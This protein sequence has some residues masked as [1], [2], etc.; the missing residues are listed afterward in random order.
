MRPTLLLL[1]C[2]L[3]LAALGLAPA[4]TPSADQIKKLIEQLGDDSYAVRQK[5]SETLYKLGAPALDALQAATKH[6][7]A[8]VRRRASELYSRIEKVAETQQILTPTLVHLAFKNVPLNTAL[9]DFRK[10]SGFPIVLLDPDNKLASTKVT[11]DTGKVTFWS[12]LDKF[13][14]AAG[15]RESDNTTL[16]RT[17]GRPLP[18]GSAVLFP[19]GTATPG[20]VTRITL[21]AGKADKVAAET[22]TSIRFRQ[23]D[24]RRA[25]GAPAAT[26][27]H[28][29]IELAI[30]PKVRWQNTQSVHLDKA[31]DDQDQRLTPAPAA[32]APG[33]MPGGPRAAPLPLD[34]G[35]RFPAGGN[36]LYHYVPIRLKKDTK[37]SK[38]LKELAGTVTGQVLTPAEAMVVVESP[39]KA[40]G[41]TIKGKHGTAI[42]VTDVI[43]PADGSFQLTFQLE[44]PTSVLAES[45]AAPAPVPAPSGAPGIGRGSAGAKPEAPVFVVDVR[46]AG[47][48]P[49]VLGGNP[50]GLTLR[51]AKDN[52]IQAVVQHSFRRGVGLG[53]AT[54][55]AEYV[56]AGTGEPA[57]LVFTGRRLVPLTVPFTLKDVVLR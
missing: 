57:K 30:E 29:Q 50:F 43:Q 42:K 39:L 45:P 9:E 20:S 25:T 2:L 4:D 19:G 38:L 22:S 26:D 11:L 23:A 3:G 36:G 17:S 52:V 34:I 6:P 7:D 49:A 13:C 8:E 44:Q 55:T 24:A 32:A 46:E 41:K 18:V 31:I 14:H 28:V 10:Q 40:K 56:A 1:A 5:A 12:A 47:V 37:E 54:P 53:A 15:V 33:P 51:D 21:V 48:G 16:P 27:L 35:F